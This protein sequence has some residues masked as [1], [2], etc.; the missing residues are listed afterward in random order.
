MF[1]IFEK[2]MFLKIQQ[3]FFE[4]VSGY[5]GGLSPPP[6]TRVSA[7]AQRE[8]LRSETGAWRRRT[9]PGVGCA[10]RVGRKTRCTTEKRQRHGTGYETDRRNT[11]A[12]DDNRPAAQSRWTNVPTSSTDNRFMSRQQQYFHN[13]YYSGGGPRTPR[14][15]VSL[16]RDGRR[17]GIYDRGP[18]ASPTV[19]TSVRWRAHTPAAVA[20][21]HERSAHV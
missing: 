3:I 5:Q 14:A 9:D 6:P 8:S 4:G 7:I 11:K 18:A 21:I 10:R 17:C 12:Y 1:S 2:E 20:L 15:P 19:A 16:H 13:D